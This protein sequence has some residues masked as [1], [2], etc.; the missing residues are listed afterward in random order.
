MSA[1]V[2]RVMHRG[3]ESLL[4]IVAGLSFAILACVTAN[5]IRA[6]IASEKFAAK[7]ALVKT[8]SSY[9]SEYTQA[10]TAGSK[11]NHT[12]ASG[13]IIGR[14]EI[15][16][17]NMSVPVTYGIEGSSLLQ[18]VGHV[19]GTAVPGGLGTIVLA[20]HRDTYLRPLEHIKIGMDVR[21]IDQTEIFHY[22]VDSWEIVTP[23]QVDSIAIHSRPELALIT[24]YP[25]HFIGPAP[26][27]FIVHAHLVSLLP[28]THR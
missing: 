17:L 18:G 5:A 14:I 26:K 2:V 16:N 28:D 20:G 7:L 11:A 9:Q 1:T 19:E 10:D 3:V 21:V 12:L 27:R 23:E 15:P 8:E 25:F 13:Q 24:C 6:Q 22:I 4:W